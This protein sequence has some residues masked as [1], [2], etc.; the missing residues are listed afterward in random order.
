MVREIFICFFT[1]HFIHC[2]ADSPICSFQSPQ[3]NRYSRDG[4]II[5]AGFFPMHTEWNYQDNSFTEWEKP[6]VCDRYSSV[7]YTWLQTMIFTI[8]EINAN[9][10][11][12]PNISLGFQLFDTCFS[13]SRSLWGTLWTLSGTDKPIL[14][15]QCHKKVPLVLFADIISLTSIAIATLLSVYRYPQIS[16][17]SSL[18]SLNNR[19]LYPSFFRTTSSDDNQ[20]QAL[21]QLVSYM[22][23]KWVGLLSLEEEYGILGSQVLKQELQ[24]LGVCI[25]YHETFGPRSSFIKMQYITDIVIQSSAK[26][27]IVF[28]RDP[29]TNPLVELL[30][31]KGVTDQIW[32]ACDGWAN[33]VIL[34][35]SKFSQTMKGTIGLT[36]HEVDMPGLKEF[37][38]AIRPFNV[39]PDDIF[40]K[41]MW[42]IVQGCRWPEAEVYA[43]NET[44]WCTGEEKLERF[45]GTDYEFNEYD[46]STSYLVYN[47]VYAVA[48]ALH[49]LIFCVPGKGLS[50]ECA[51][52]K[53]INPWQ[54]VH[55]L[56]K[57]NFTNK[58]GEQMYFNQ[59]GTTP[60]DYDVVNWQR[61]DDGTIKFVNVGRYNGRKP[62][63]NELNINLSA[64]QWKTGVELPRSVCSESCSPGFH[65]AAQKGQP[66][67]CF[68]CIPCFEGEISNETD[69]TYCFPCPEE[70]WPS[71]NK[72]I[73]VP[74][75]LEF[76]SFGDALGLTL[77]LVVLFCCITTMS[78]LCVFITYRDTAIV[79]ANNRDLTYLLL[80]C[81]FCG[82]LC[83][84]LFIGEPG[85]LTCLLRQVAFG[86]IFAF[87]VSCVLAKTLMV[88]IAFRATKPGS[89]MRKWMGTRVPASTVFICTILQVFICICWLYIC[90]PFPEKNMKIKTGVII[91]QC[92]DCFEALLWCM[93]GYMAFLACVCF[94]VAFL[95]RNLP[96]SFNE[97]KWITFSMLIFLSVWV[98]FVPAYLSTQGRYMVSVEVFAIISSSAGILVCIFFPKCYIILLRPDMNT[99]GNI[100]VRG[101]SQK[102]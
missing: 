1:F 56:K 29:V 96:D 91:F 28:S 54:I 8:E 50:P 33:S 16:F 44:V 37:L 3:L 15:Y 100:L 43:K 5:L 24:I 32:V 85:Q 71:R 53:T 65:K 20:A 12:L 84:L 23:W 90:P 95:A 99:R 64:I 39:L 19:F 36:L 62:K 72:T 73:C 45:K 61:H 86:I 14:N 41:K 34:S 81:L 46:F 82:F 7:S 22:G 17:R 92:N 66:I 83:S 48:N 57:V 88:V 18:T 93:L 102:A 21:A 76:L 25:A 89:N 49:E 79:I 26:V 70:A 87:S 59:Y 67:C 31:Q 101:S 40:I 30:V 10:A 2:L 42:E 6:M 51:D 98:S 13:I 68:D 60:T 58:M 74:K 77:T 94:V 55:Y 97:A 9:T 47:A 4:D 75:A 27:V 69:S 78:I 11:L 35:I 63:G 38:L 52:P 80:V